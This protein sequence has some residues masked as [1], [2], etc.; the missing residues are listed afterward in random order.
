M[1]NEKYLFVV[2]GAAGT[3]KDSVVKALREAHPEIE[4]TVSATTR[5]PRPGEQ[6]GVDYYYRTREQFQKLI[7]DDEVVEYNFYNGNYYGTLKEEVNKRLNAGKLVVL[8]ID[9]HGAANIRRMYP[10]ATTVFLLPPSEEELERRLRGRGTETEES[11]RERL[12]TAKQELAQQD[13]FAVKLVN[14]EI[15]PCAEE[16]YQVI[17][18]SGTIKDIHG[19][20]IIT[21]VQHIIDHRTKWC[22]S[23]TSGDKQQIFTFQ[24]ILHRKMV[25]IGSADGDL[26]AYFQAVQRLCQASAFL[27]TKLLIF[28]ICR[29]GSNRKHSLTDSWYTQHGTLSRHMFK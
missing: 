23:D 2:S 12:A 7:E 29:R 3:G 1:E 25:S 28:L 5:S 14:N 27:D 10:G 16:L 26:I 20:I 19:T 24:L 15:G 11:I 17:C 6:E 18:R 22:K 13:H 21:V 8:V 4:K 9:V